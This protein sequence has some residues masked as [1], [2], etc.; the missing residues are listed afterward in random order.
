MP[1]CQTI[2]VKEAARRLGVS[3]ATGYRGAR[4]GSIPA[5]RVRGRLLVL[6]EPFERMLLGKQLPRE[7]RRGS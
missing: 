7:P 3:P 6:R 4:D 2:P 5:I 1:H